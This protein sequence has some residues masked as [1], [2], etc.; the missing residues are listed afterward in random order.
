M[1]SVDWFEEE[2]KTRRFANTGRLY[3]E[4]SQVLYY[5]RQ[6]VYNWPKALWWP[7]AWLVWLLHLDSPELETTFYALCAAVYEQDGWMW[8]YLQSNE[9]WR[10]EVSWQAGAVKLVHK[11]RP[12]II[13]FFPFG[14]FINEFNLYCIAMGQ[15]L[16]NFAGISNS[17]QEHFSIWLQIESDDKTLI[18]CC[19]FYKKIYCHFHFERHMNKN[20]W[21]SPLHH[22]APWPWGKFN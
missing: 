10:W 7:T 15:N 21:H 8:L 2:K 9:N 6:P 18:D 3:F 22:F 1:P 16:A 4:C 12:K 13:C 19:T 20:H 5:Y 11:Q 14:L 17:C